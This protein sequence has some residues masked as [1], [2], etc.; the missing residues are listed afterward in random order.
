MLSNQHK[1]KP[2]KKVG[3]TRERRQRKEA[4]KC[5]YRG[6]SEGLGK[7]NPADDRRKKITKETHTKNSFRK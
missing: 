7:E 3:R 5:R 4:R 1:A 6:R 2:L